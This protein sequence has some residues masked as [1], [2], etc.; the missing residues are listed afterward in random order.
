[1]SD[2]TDTT[3][4]HESAMAHF[5]RKMSGEMQWVD[6]AEWGN[7]SPR[8]IYFRPSMN[9][10]DQGEV[11]K[12]SQEGK[13]AEA[14]AMTLILRARTRSHTTEIMRYYDPDVLADI[15]NRMTGG[16]LTDEEIAGN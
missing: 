16:E 7:G 10:K 8:R 13:I 12:L 9:L 11:M 14:L 1:M 2:M 5:K 3:D 4:I 15:V 6:V